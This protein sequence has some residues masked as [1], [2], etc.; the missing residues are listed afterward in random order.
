MVTPTATSCT[1]RQNE[2]RTRCVIR[3]PSPT[4][5]IATSVGTE[6]VPRGRAV[7]AVPGVPSRA[8][9]G[10]RDEPSSKGLRP[11]QHK[12][13]PVPTKRDV[14]AS[15]RTWVGG[16]FYWLVNGHRPRSH[17]EAPEVR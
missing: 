2:S 17:A 1:S 7:F 3:T 15:G 14:C 8:L 9:R 10:T 16:S 11:Q 13:R 6:R 5:E 4:T 12:C